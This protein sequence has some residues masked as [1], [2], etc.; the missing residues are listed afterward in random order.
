MDSIYRQPKMDLNCY[1]LNPLF[2]KLAKEQ[3]TAFLLSDFNVDLLKYEQ[4]KPTNEF[5]RFLVCNIFSPY[6]ARPTR[7][8]SH[9]PLITY[10]SII[11]NIFSNYISQETGNLKS[12]ISDHL[13]QFLI[14]TQIFSNASNKKSSIFERVWSKLNHEKFVLDYFAIDC[15]HTLK[16]QGS[17]VFDMTSRQ[18]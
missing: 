2:E 3:K 15:P 10:K 18:H 7:I 9:L 4:R 1:Y 17:K 11:D 12:T 8:T 16:L 13:S 6:V 5:L 14:T